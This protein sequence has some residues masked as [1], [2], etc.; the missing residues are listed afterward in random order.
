MQIAAV[1]SVY[2]LRDVRVVHS[3]PIVQLHGLFGIGAAGTARAFP[4]GTGLVRERIMNIEESTCV[5]M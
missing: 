1:A 5:T 3:G 2:S 4:W